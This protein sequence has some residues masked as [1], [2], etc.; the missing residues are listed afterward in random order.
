MARSPP[1]DGGGPDDALW[2]IG[3][4]GAPVRGRHARL[5]AG[6]IDAILRRHAYPRPV[7]LMLGEAVTLAALIGA[8]LKQFVCLTIQAQGDGP[9]PLLVAQCRVGGALRGYVR[10]EPDAAALLGGVAAMTPAALLGRGAL[11]VTLDPGEGM[12]KVQGIV[13][14]EADSLGACA[15][16][17]FQDS[18]Q[19]PTRIR[20]AVAECITPDA[21]AL[22]R[23]GG[24]F[25]QRVA[26]DGVRGDT[27][28]DWARA[29]LL[30]ATVA[31]AELTDPALG[32][33]RLLYRLFHEEGVR[34]SAPSRMFDACPC[35]RERLAAVL[36]R[37]SAEEIAEL[38]EADGAIHA[39]CQFCG[40]DYIFAA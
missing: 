14:L 33:E 28:D 27:E 29:Q 12:P 21:P 22:W 16:A 31:D 5:G 6:S 23:A 18:V 38:R 24:L 2:E 36:G 15:E 13:S 26:G 10:M 20:V 34:V 1:G 17:Y 35:D 39:R 3:L 32:A 25:L 19:T 37:L 7:A 30:L 9:V 40:R 11:A 4:E 8:S